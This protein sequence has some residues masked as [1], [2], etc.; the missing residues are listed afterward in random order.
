M[1]NRP[2]GIAVIKL[3]LMNL[4]LKVGRQTARDDGSRVGREED[5][6]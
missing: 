3:L 2:E 4:K 1:S 6:V 5:G